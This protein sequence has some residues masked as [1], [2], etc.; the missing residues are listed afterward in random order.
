MRVALLNP[1]DVTQP[2]SWLCQT[3]LCPVMSAVSIRSAASMNVGASEKLAILF[4]KCGDCITATESK[5]STRGL[6]GIL[7]LRFSSLASRILRDS[8]PFHTVC[9]ENE[10]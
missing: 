5:G 10:L 2:G 7:S 4:R 3:Q 6:G 1:P 8:Y 9:L